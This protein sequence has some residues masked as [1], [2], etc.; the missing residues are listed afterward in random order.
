M[1]HENPTT[2]EV[3]ESPQPSSGR[4]LRALAD[5]PP[6]ALLD[7]PAL[8]KALDVSPRTVR[9]MVARG[10]IPPGVKLGGRATWLAGRVLDR[11]ARAAAEAEK[12][13]RGKSNSRILG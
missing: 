4:V 1:N 11:I 12:A 13:W 9:A 10:E 7:E 5:L 2:T 3:P 8:A 6:G